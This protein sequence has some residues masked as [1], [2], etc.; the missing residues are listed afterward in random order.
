MIFSGKKEKKVIEL[1]NEHITR[2]DQCLD[3]V[4][5]TIRNYLDGRID[6]AKELS[7]QTHLM[8]SEADTK[9]RAIIQN[10]FEG[11]FLPVYRDG[12][13]R[14]VGMTDKIADYG[15]S[16]CDFTLC[17]RPEIPEEF[18]KDILKMT[19]DSLACFKP[20]K[21]AVV[22]LFKD[23][24]ILR[25]KTHE[26]NVL[27]ANVDKDE[28]DAVCGIFSSNLPLA[29]KIHLRDFIWHITEISDICQNAADSLEVLV[30]QK[31]V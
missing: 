24:T 25:E 9:R 4:G 5:K 2:V 14:F 27:E 3:F 15:E 22:N 13:V 1:I 17:Q 26:V 29:Q 12:M 18:K 20:F 10:L 19:D 23:Y 6:E 21:E 28:W 11:A 8:E 16:C 31:S 7:Y 30:V